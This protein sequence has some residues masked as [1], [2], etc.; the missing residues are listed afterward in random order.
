MLY[1]CFSFYMLYISTY[2]G[3]TSDFEE[4]YIFKI[5]NK[6]WTT[7][8]SMYSAL[9]WAVIVIRQS[10]KAFLVKLDVYYK[11]FSEQHLTSH[12]LLIIGDSA[13]DPGSQEH[14][15][16]QSWHNIGRLS[17]SASS[18]YSLAWSLV[19]YILVSREL[20]TFYWAKLTL[21]E[22]WNWQ[23]SSAKPEYTIQHPAD[24][25]LYTGSVICYL[26][27]YY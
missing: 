26:P 8:H 2:L 15:T 10:D 20:E 9:Y 11:P 3:I 14:D 17:E 24:A 5:L 21:A 13:K 27:V 22:L 18:C 16:C 6:R 7:L 12:P 1:C 19:Y 4:N 25:C 23:D